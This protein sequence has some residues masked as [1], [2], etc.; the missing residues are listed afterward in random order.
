[1]VSNLELEHTV[2]CDR[3]YTGRSDSTLRVIMTKRPLQSKQ[4]RHDTESLLRQI[5]LS[6]SVP[7]PEETR[8][9]HIFL[10]TVP[11]QLILHILK[12]ILG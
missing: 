7:I 5:T 2:M 10:D 1:M 4:P 12:D 11:P 8:L 3:S 6:P 9:L